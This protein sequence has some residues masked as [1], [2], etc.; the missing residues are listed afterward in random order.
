MKAGYLIVLV[1]LASCG[2]KTS[3]DR[4]DGAGSDSPAAIDDDTEGGAL[5][6]GGG[7]GQACRLDGTCDPGLVCFF[8]DDQCIMK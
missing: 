3:I 5:Q 2:S 8:T 6:G 1:I 7:L 4:L